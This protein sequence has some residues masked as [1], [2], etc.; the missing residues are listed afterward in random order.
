MII[1]HSELKLAKR[2]LKRIKA[3][4]CKFAIE[5]EDEE[6]Y[7]LEVVYKNYIRM[8]EILWSN[9]L[10][11]GL[12]GFA[13]WVYNIAQRLIFHEFN[14]HFKIDDKRVM[15]PHFTGY[16]KLNDFRKRK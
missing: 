4:D 14:E 13:G 2:W 15:N 6:H 8:S 11:R 12:P 1:K 16:S 9:I 3:M 10:E 5:L 7:R